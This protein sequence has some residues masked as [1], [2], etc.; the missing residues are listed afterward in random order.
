MRSRRQTTAT[1]TNDVGTATPVVPTGP[2]QATPPTG[3]CTLA[4]QNFVITG[5]QPPYNV[6]STAGQPIPAS[7]PNNP[8]QFAFTLLNTN[9][10]IKTIFIGDSGVP[11]KS[12]SV[13]ITCP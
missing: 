8:G 1:L 2:V 10:G 3:Q 7:V 12:F 11:Q 6:A 5:G 9:A 13:T 4:S